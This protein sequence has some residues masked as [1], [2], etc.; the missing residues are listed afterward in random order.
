MMPLRGAGA[1]VAGCEISRA[2][3]ALGTLVQISAWGVTAD[4]TARA[5]GA[6]FDAITAVERLMSFHHPDSEL[7][8][9]NLEACRGPQTVHP[10]TLAVL[11]RA[12][13]IAAAS[14][15]LFDPSV[16]P[17]LVRLGQLPA[18]MPL[19][20]ECGSWRDVRIGLGGDVSFGRPLLLDLG[21]IAKG[22]AVDQAVHAL[23]AG[24]CV[25][26]VVNAGGDLR[27]FGHRWN[28]IEVRDRSG[29]RPLLE[30]RCGA[31]ATSA[32]PAPRAGR[33]LQPAG[34]IIE[35][36]TGTRWVAASGVTVVAT[37][38]VVADAL[39]KV[40]ALGGSR[41][42]SVLDRFGARVFRDDGPAATVQRGNGVCDQG[43]SCC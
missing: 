4:E 19:P 38:C 36:S 41:A 5:V 25:E 21:G 30:L 17:V 13:R 2:R 11:R 9:L 28:T 43:E 40:A 35:P 37:T 22:F 20:R 42:A 33:L 7:T 16:A 27:R 23:R 31:V 24:G 12:L 39:T 6:A 29:P 14:D 10:W 34:C 26:A 8:R 3:P 18:H 1:G 32:P 15:G